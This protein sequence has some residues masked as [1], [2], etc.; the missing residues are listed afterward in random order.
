MGLLKGLLGKH[1]AS[2]SDGSS[3]ASSGPG[4]QRLH[5]WIESRI[6]PAK[7][8]DPNTK[9]R[10]ED[11]LTR[12]KARYPSARG[13]VTITRSG[14]DTIVS[15]D[16]RPFKGRLRGLGLQWD[17]G[18]RSWIAKNKVISEN[19]IDMPSELAGLR[20][21]IETIPYRSKF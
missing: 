10:I 16:T 14:S 4:Y 20:K 1:F 21:Y 12:E 8:A 3:S 18:T 15:G 17:R 13:S 5:R 19:D 2:G 9:A 6:G 11:L 7:P